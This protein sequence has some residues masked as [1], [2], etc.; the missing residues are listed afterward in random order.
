MVFAM[1]NN[2]LSSPL[3]TPLSEKKLFLFDIDGTLAVG[4]TLFEGSRALLDHIASIGGKSYYITNNSTKSGDDYVKRFREVF[5][6]DST[7]DLFI[8]SG[9]MTIQFLKKNFFV[10]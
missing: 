9:Y 7:Q 3:G 1:A 8:T 10:I 5:G 2:R 4:D 6:L